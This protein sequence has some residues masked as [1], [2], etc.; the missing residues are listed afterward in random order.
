MAPLEF[1]VDSLSSQGGN[2]IN[3]KELAFLFDKST[4]AH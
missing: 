4:Y 1:E 2:R 3:K